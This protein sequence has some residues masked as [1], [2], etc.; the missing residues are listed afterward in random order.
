MITEKKQMR[1]AIEEIENIRTYIE[2]ICGQKKLS[3][4][5]TLN[6]CL[7]AEELM[8][9][10]LAHAKENQR[11]FPENLTVEK[12]IKF[13]GTYVKISYFA[14]EFNPINDINEIVDINTED[15]DYYSRILLRS[16]KDK[17]FYQYKNGKNCIYIALKKTENMMIQKVI[18]TILLGIIAGMIFKV[19]PNQEI[20]NA[21]NTYLL[22]P[23]TTIFLNALKML[24][25]PVVFFSIVSCVSGLSNIS[26]L[27]RIGGKVMG[28]YFITTFLAIG[29]GL[30]VYMAFQPENISLI[31]T[32]ADDASTITERAETINVSILDTIVNIVPSNLVSPIIEGNMLQVIFVA[33]LS[34]IAVGII[35]NNG[36]IL[37]DIFEAC[38]QLFLRITSI[39]IIAIPVAIFC[40]MASMVIKLGWEKLSSLLF[41]MLIFVAGLIAMIILY[42]ILI[43]VLAKESPIPFLKKIVPFMTT[44]FALGSSN[45]CM[46]MTM[47]LCTD[48][49]GISKKIASFSIPLG[50]TMNMD[51]SSIYLVVATLFLAKMYH[52]DITSSTIATI[53]I[54]TFILSVGAPGVPGSGLI[55]LSM[56]VVQIGIPVESI[57]LIMGL[58]R[59]CGMCRTA[60]NITGDVAVSLIVSK[61]EGLLNKEIYKR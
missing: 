41:F 6:R 26:E 20:G 42:A 45:A 52:I 9:L 59:I 13:D 11:N 25:A 29:L 61:W 56:L 46:P 31:Q 23:V 15:E 21:V 12:V 32:V 33:V 2:D 24:M 8:T 17:I 54:T 39:V 55:C 22:S 44:P 5:E 4:K 38:N 48:K 1:F 49:L 50:A 36:K 28:M 16:Q 57:G 34:G 51:G 53:V 14:E 3:L 19:L 43:F 10:C 30:V 60:S 27:G 35:G 18:L 37:S 47:Q 58:D 40:A 7:I